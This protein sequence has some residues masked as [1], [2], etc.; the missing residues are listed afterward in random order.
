MTTVFLVMGGLFV[1]LAIVQVAIVWPY[2]RYV[3]RYET[4]EVADENL[5]HA[6]IVMALRGADPFIKQCLNQLSDQNYP[7]YQVQLVVDN[8]RDTALPAVEEWQAAHPELKVVVDFLR[9]PGRDCTLYCSSLHQ[10]VTALGPEVEIVAFANADTMPHANWLRSLVAPLLAPGVGAV[11]GNRWYLPQSGKWG[12]LVRYVQNASAIVGM[13]LMGLIWGGSLALKRSVFTSPV[14]L[15]RLRNAC[16][17]DHA[18]Y[19]TLKANREKLVF[20]PA[21]LMVN[22]EE[23]TLP[24]GFRF[25]R[26]QLG[27]T[28]I[29]HPSW[30][31]LVVHTV[32][33]TA[34]VAATYALGIA[35]IIRGQWQELGWMLGGL[36]IFFAAHV[37][38]LWWTH[39]V[40]MRRVRA[41]QG[42]AGRLPLW[43]LPKLFIAIP[44]TLYVH[45][46]TVFSAAWMRQ[47][48][49]R[50]IRYEFVSPRSIRLVAYQ[51][52]Q[53]TPAPL[54][55]NLSL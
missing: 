40:V 41:E 51:P 54:Q 48:E 33:T 1:L 37:L 31:Q 27:W 50:G 34:V 25:I 9:D 18:I 4:P 8:P 22:R 5:P 45:I 17:E 47:V 46:A 29:Y 24:S 32:I 44:L 43:L 7:S 35:A 6:A 30:N 13:H 38:T 19:E 26:R 16:C 42:D 2:L 23:C 10:G 49:W 15:H 11:T 55:E 3:A 52:Y 12:S 53:Q 28:R 14:F 20:T 21:V 39:A 36:A